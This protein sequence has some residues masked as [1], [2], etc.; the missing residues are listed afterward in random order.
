M[1]KAYSIFTTIIVVIIAALAVLLVTGNLLGM[2]AYSVLSGS[3]APAI[4][5]G[6]LVYVHPVSADNVKEG[7]VITFT[8][9]EN[10]TL[11]THRVVTVFDDNGTKSFQTKGDANNTADGHIVTESSYVGRVL[12]TLPKMGILFERIHEGPG[13]A[14]AIA[15]GIVL[16]LLVSLPDI[17]SK[18]A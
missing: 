16:V 3:M 9:D 1:R 15:A 4:N 13:R 11:A 17:V 14:V 10:D 5:V 2:K 6:D 12:V 8:V 18:H 7:D